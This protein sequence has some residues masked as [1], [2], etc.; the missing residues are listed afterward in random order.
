MLKIL[1]K[2]MSFF[3]EEFEPSMIEFYKNKADYKTDIQNMK[4]LK[5]PII[6]DNKEKW[7]LRNE[8]K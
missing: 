8:F 2:N 6:K 7:R 5:K 3:G 1:R 4:N